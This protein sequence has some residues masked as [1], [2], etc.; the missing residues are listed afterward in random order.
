MTGKTS[1]GHI[2]YTATASYTVNEIPAGSQYELVTSDAE[3]GEN[4]EY[5]IMNK[6]S[7]SGYAMSTDQRDNNR[8]QT[9][10][11]S[12]IDSK[13][14]PTDDTQILTLEAADDGWY[15]KV[16]E[17]KY[18]YAVAGNN[19]LRTGQNLEASDQYYVAKI[20]IGET[21][22]VATIEFATTGSEKRYLRRNNNSEIFSCYTTGQQEVYLYK[23]GTATPT[24]KTPTFDPAGG[25]YTSAQS[26]TISCATDE[27]AIYY[28]TDGVTTPTSESTPYNGPISVTQTTTIKAIAI[29]DGVSSSVAE[30]TYTINIPVIGDGDYVKITKLSD[31]TNGDYLIVNEFEGTGLMTG[32]VF[33]GNLTTLDKSGNTL[34]EVV[35]ITDYTIASSTEVD[36]A[37]FTITATGDAYTIKSKSEYY[38]GT[39]QSGNRLDTSTETAYTNTISFDNDGNAVIESEN[40]T[41]L[42][43]NSSDDRFR[44]YGSG[45]SPIALYKKTTTP[46]VESKTLADIEAASNA[47]N[48]GTKYAIADDYLVAVESRA[49]GSDVLVWCKDDNGATKI[50]PAEGVTDFMQPTNPYWDQSNWVVLRFK[51]AGTADFGP[52][53]LKGYKITNIVGTYVNANNYMID[54]ESYDT[55]GKA[56]EYT[57]NVYC[58]ANFNPSYWGANGVQATTN[59]KRYFFMTPKVQEVCTITFAQWSNNKFI[60]PTSSGFPWAISSLDWTY[61]QNRNEQ[62]TTLNDIIETLNKED[63]AD[64]IYHFT[65]V[66]QRTE[67]SGG[68]TPTPAPSLKGSLTDG[69]IVIYP[70]DFDASDNNIVDPVTAINTVEIGNGE[71]KSVK[72][73]NVAGIVSDRPFSGVN[74]VVTEYSDGSR[75]T[76]KMLRK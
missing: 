72:Y 64:N 71:V 10:E 31:L 39:T 35:E 56:D 53:E 27:A 76:T 63:N 1:Y 14:I 62:P 19:Y 50:T 42:R 65:S 30:A 2:A 28:T 51:G 24:V 16:E 74:I 54:V 4:V 55:D 59:G 47:Q 23:K 15:L 8:G 12:V 25:T 7:G 70:M 5:V 36:N 60:V 61:N 52:S 73:V 68:T 46:V 21:S 34:D 3:L 37:I 22:H 6:A 13:I 69:N 29:K 20:S 45:Q 32:F 40:G 33:N 11:I 17:G 75:T 9:G 18:L 43:Y 41:Y 67:N 48:V 66:V 44:Y 26:V 58:V 49:V 38:I 57:P